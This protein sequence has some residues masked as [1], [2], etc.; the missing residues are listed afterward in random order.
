MYNIRP[1]NSLCGFRGSECFTRTTC[2]LAKAQHTKRTCG[3]PNQLDETRPL[4]PVNMGYKKKQPRL[5]YNTYLVLTNKVQNTALATQPVD[6]KN[7]AGGCITTTQF[8]ANLVQDTKR[9]QRPP[10]LPST[11]SFDTAICRTLSRRRLPHL[12]QTLQHRELLF[13]IAFLVRHL[14]VQQNRQAKQQ[15]RRN[16][17][18]KAS[19]SIGK[20]RSRMLMPV[21]RIEKACFYTC[22]SWCE[23]TSQI[24]FEHWRSPGWGASA[25]QSNFT[26][27]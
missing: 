26:H 7:G 19:A 22:P 17:I 15:C 2:H 23:R 9:L 3:K 20:A 14:R 21:L 24:L 16:L 8:L 5:L 18:R 13:R 12:A 25:Q 6:T 4:L 10:S 27:V 1:T 11:S